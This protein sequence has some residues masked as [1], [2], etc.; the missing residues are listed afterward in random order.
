MAKRRIKTKSHRQ[1]EAGRILGQF[2]LIVFV[3]VA[4]L[5]AYVGRYLTT[6]FPL[7]NAPRAFVLERGTTMRMAANQ[8]AADG[9]V[10]EPWLF[11][12]VARFNG[13]APRIKAGS[14]ELNEAVTPLQLLAKLTDGDVTSATLTLVEGWTWRQ[15]KAALARHPDLRHDTQH[16]GDAELLTKLGVSGSSV[17]GLLFPDTY[18]F[19]K[20]SS[21]IQVLKRAQEAMQKQLAAAWEARAA[22]LP[23]SQPYEALILAS[24]IEKET[25]AAKDRAMIASVFHNRLRIGMRLQTDPTVIYGLGEAFDGNLR[26]LHLETDSPYNSYTRSGLP[27]T[28]IAMPGMA[29][30][31][32][33]TNP[34]Q[35]KAL[36]FV[37]KGDGSSYFS[38]SLAEHNQ[39]VRRYLLGAK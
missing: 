8:L 37:A 5:A 2:L 26:K 21:D 27:P 32:A 24:I 38:T 11:S 6:P 18:H 22:N 16:L 35:S 12:L 30:L 28:P 23:L 14:Y 36:Y 1:Y 19:A 25:G 20:Q 33:A 4:A 13:A 10:T 3:L 15:V 31:L 39:A 7:D 29:S 34:A 17:E 9:L